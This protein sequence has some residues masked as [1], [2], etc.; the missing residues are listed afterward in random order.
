[1]HSGVRL[2][3]GCY[4]AERAAQLA[5]VSSSTVYEWARIGLVVPSI[6]EVQPMLWSYADLME[7]RIVAWLRHAKR[8][9]GVP[10]S[11][12]RQVRDALDT[13]RNRGV[14]L[15]SPADDGGRTPLAVDR[16]GRVFVRDADGVRDATGQGVLSDDLLD[17]LGPFDAGDTWGPDL[18]RPAPHLRIV[19]AKLG[20][21]P[22]LDGTRLTTRAVAALAARGLTVEAISRLLPT[23]DVDALAEAV[24]LERRL[25]A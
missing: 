1:M 25:A 8:D 5:G 24:E 22:H 10:A 20:G 7:L 16:S 19:A 4:E 2:F 12:M 6:S 18:R 21:E 11:P 17:V 23:H 14:E 15:W 9:A 3:E 13:L